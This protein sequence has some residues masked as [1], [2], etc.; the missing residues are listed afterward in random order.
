M[1]TLKQGDKAPAFKAKDQDGNLHQLKDYKGQKLALYFYPRDNTPTC[2]VQACNLRDNYEALKK[3]GITILGVSTDDEQSHKKF[4]TKHQ[5]PFPLLEDSAHTMVHAYGVWGP[6]KF[7][8]KEFDGTH[9]TTFLI[10][11]KGEIAYV[12]EK[13]KS[14]EHADQILETWKMI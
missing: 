7:M 4:E 6:K 9:R 2:T 8:G 5:L 3:A 14:K 13:V 1:T 12:I 11:E 10:D